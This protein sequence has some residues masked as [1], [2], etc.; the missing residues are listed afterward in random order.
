VQ[1]FPLNEMFAF[2]F[3]LSRRA[4]NL[5]LNTRDFTIPET[6][7]TLGVLIIGNTK[8]V[9][10]CIIRVKGKEFAFFPGV[11]EEES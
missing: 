1:K 8:L 6:I 4:L 3:L 11:E 5:K 7:T 9:S 2:E 10:I